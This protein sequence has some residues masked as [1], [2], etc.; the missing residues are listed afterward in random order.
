MN[1]ATRHEEVVYTRDALGIA[2]PEGGSNVITENLVG[3]TVLAPASCGR[4]VQTARGDMHLKRLR[5]GR[6][7]R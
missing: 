5:E 1:R 3:E 6:S 7:Y 4:T 2:L